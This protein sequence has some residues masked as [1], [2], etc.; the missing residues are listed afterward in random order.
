MFHCGQ[1]DDDDD[2]DNDDDMMIRLHIHGR[3]SSRPL[4]EL[5]PIPS[6]LLFPLSP[7]T[8]HSPTPAISPFPSFLPLFPRRPT[9]NRRLVKRV[10]RFHPPENSEILYCCS[11]SGSFSLFLV[12]YTIRTVS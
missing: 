12:Q 7:P 1:Y 8:F 3:L 6:P 9:T 4:A 10:P 11:L 2:D 5:P